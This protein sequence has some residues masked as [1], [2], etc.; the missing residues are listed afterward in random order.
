MIEKKKKKKMKGGFNPSR[1]PNLCPTIFNA[2][3][4]LNDWLERRSRGPTLASDWNPN[5]RPCSRPFSESAWRSVDR[6]RYTAFGH[7]LDP[8]AI[9]AF[10][11][12]YNCG[13]DQEGRPSGNG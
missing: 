12:G 1:T 10:R 6:R 7:H 3:K 9:L 13:N 2:E 8:D 4:K 5:L 11:L